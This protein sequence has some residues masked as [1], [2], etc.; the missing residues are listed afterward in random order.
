MSDAKIPIIKLRDLDLSSYPVDKIAQIMDEFGLFGVIKLTLFE[1]RIII[2]ARPNERNLSFQHISDL[3]YK[4]EKYN[5]EF[6]RASIPNKS[7]FY[8]CFVPDNVGEGELDD[9]RLAAVFETS[10]LY[11]KNIKDGEEIITLSYWMVKNDIPLIAIVY[12]ED[13]IDNSS[14]TKELFVAYQDFL[15]KNSRDTAKSSRLITD[16]IANEFAKKEIFHDFDYLISAIFTKRILDQGLAGVFYPSV[17]TEGKLFNVAI[18]P[19]FV[20]NNLIIDYVSE[21]TIR[22]KNNEMRLDINSTTHIEPGQTEF[23]LTPYGTTN[24]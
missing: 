1:G 15:L 7:M 20:K 14:Y 21:Y 9:A 5:K 11:R 6:Q 22:R 16:Y 24:Q 18:H 12:H 2:R 13:F 3:T 19:N 23:V 10:R 17:R 4:P 8:G